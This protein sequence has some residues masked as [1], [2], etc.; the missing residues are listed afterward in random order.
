MK[1]ETGVSKAVSFL[2][3]CYS[4]SKGCQYS[5]TTEDGW[6]DGWMENKG[7]KIL[8]QPTS[9]K[10]LVENNGKLL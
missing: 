4:Y 3:D 5:Y 6:M 9:L 1:F 8:T 10:I 7:M 2:V